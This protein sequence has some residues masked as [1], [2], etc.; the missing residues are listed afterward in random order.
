[1]DPH[2]F[3]KHQSERS[4]P[5]PHQNEGSDPDPRHCCYLCKADGLPVTFP[6]PVPAP[7]R[8]GTDPGPQIRNPESRA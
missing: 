2:H 5:D 8:S 6:D 3:G 1:M 4:E 7:V